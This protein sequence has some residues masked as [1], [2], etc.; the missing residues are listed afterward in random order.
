MATKR[1]LLDLY[2]GNFTSP[3][4]DHVVLLEA[5]GAMDTTIIPLTPEGHIAQ[6]LLEVIDAK[7]M[8][9]NIPF[10]VPNKGPDAGQWN[11][12]SLGSASYVFFLVVLQFGNTML[13]QKI[14]SHDLPSDETKLGAVEGWTISVSPAKY[15]VPRVGNS[16]AMTKL[17][18][19]IAQF[20]K[21]SKSESVGGNG[22][23]SGGKGYYHVLDLTGGKH[24]VS[25]KA[26]GVE[27][28]AMVAG[29]AREME[30]ARFKE[31]CFDLIFDVTVFKA[32]CL[33]YRDVAMSP[34][35]PNRSLALVRY[36]TDRE[37]WLNAHKFRAGV[38]G[39]FT[40]GS[41]MPISLLDFRKPQTRVWGK[42]ATVVGRMD[43]MEALMTWERFTQALKGE[44][45]AGCMQPINALLHRAD[46]PLR[47][48]HDIYIQYQLEGLLCA[49]YGEV[50]KLQG[51][52]SKRYPS[53]ALVTQADCVAFLQLLVADFVTAALN[54]G[55]AVGTWE[56]APHHLT[57]SSDSLFSSIQQPQKDTHG[58]HGVC[59]WYLAG[60]LGMLN[61]KG[62]KY[63]CRV[64]NARH[65][66][67]HTV[68]HS[69]AV[70]LT[71][72]P[73]FMAECTKNTMRDELRAKV[74]SNAAKFA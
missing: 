33:E 67:L 25:A 40:R 44:A 69:V 16:G 74:A 14:G 32:K 10:L 27:R 37:V 45:F 13:A 7:D 46:D 11:W 72:D 57:Y 6:Q 71:N 28:M 41:W 42:E 23:A 22:E 70:E 50:C 68:P 43:L 36:V 53:Q 31:F 59:P 35:D 62:A 26:V 49:Y 58:A 12:D 38:L 18:Q 19:E 39:M 60:E 20:I 56:V 15:L 24:Q 21:Q 9:V 29:L 8:G 61:A 5:L 4:A 64:A 30:P 66:P 47:V 63:G 73:S 48:Y 3:S 17:E 34:Q 55:T 65:A 1:S 2:Y 54:P 52:K 51:R